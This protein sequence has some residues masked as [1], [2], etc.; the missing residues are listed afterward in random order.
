MRSPLKYSL[1]CKHVIFQFWVYSNVLYPFFKWFLFLVLVLFVSNSFLENRENQ[2][3][4]WNCSYTYVIRQ[5]QLLFLRKKI[6]CIWQSSISSH[7][8]ILKVCLAIFHYYECKDFCV[9]KLYEGHR[10]AFITF[11]YLFYAI[12]PFPYPLK[13]SENF[14]FS[15]V[16]RG[17]WKKMGCMKCREIFRKLQAKFWRYCKTFS[18]SPNCWS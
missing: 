12:G 15:E 1:C 2:S 3:T 10:K 17:V 5:E 4:Q 8:K 18:H 13:I 7:R 16:F 11:I 14:F 9:R 6:V